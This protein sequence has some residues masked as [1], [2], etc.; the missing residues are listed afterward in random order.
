M[1]KLTLYYI[2]WIT[3]FIKCS[4]GKRTETMPNKLSFVANLQ[5]KPISVCKPVHFRFWLCVL[6]FFDCQ[7]H[8][9]NPVSIFPDTH[10]NTHKSGGSH[11]ILP[12]ENG[13]KIIVFQ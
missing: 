6:N 8:D 11:G 7:L 2:S 12:E 4:G 10:K 13:R 9:L 1:C 5:T 3:H